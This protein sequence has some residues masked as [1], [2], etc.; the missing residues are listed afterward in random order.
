ML[1]YEAILT[2]EFLAALRIESGKMV[3]HKL[4]VVTTS[5]ENSM[6]KFVSEVLDNIQNYWV[7]QSHVYASNIT[8]CTWLSL[9]EF[10]PWNL[11]NTLVQNKA[12]RPESYRG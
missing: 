11:V 12:M 8:H 1:T 5:A 6:T 2:I 3:Q 4:K 9:V 10:L 7:E